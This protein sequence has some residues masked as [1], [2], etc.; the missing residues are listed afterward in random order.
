MGLIVDAR[1]ADRE[2]RRCQVRLQG[3]LVAIALA[4]LAFGF[5]RLPGVAGVVVLLLGAVGITLLVM[6]GAM[7]LGLLGF[8]LFALFDR[9][10]G[11]AR[12]PGA[13]P[14]PDFD[15]EPRKK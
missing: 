5:L 4:A 1:T 2:R 14:D 3:L 11:G 12:D 10:I 6:L 15:A 13:W 7:A 8:G 9:I